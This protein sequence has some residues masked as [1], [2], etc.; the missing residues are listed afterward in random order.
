MF[1]FILA[2]C[3]WLPFVQTPE[4]APLPP[5]QQRGHRGLQEHTKDQAAPSSRVIGPI[6]GV[7][8]SQGN[9]SSIVDKQP[10]I[11]CVTP[12]LTGCDEIEG[13]LF[14]DSLLKYSRCG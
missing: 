9:P 13:G 4:G 2:G 12:W 3:A 5:C 7:S 14:K 10:D 11:K 8:K 1:P 6:L